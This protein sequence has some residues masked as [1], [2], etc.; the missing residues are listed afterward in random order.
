MGKAIVILWEN[1]Q[2]ASDSSDIEIMGNYIGVVFIIECFQRR[3]RGDK[4]QIRENNS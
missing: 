1:V 4:P 2:M 3:K